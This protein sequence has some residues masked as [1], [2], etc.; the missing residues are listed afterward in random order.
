MS[1][2]LPPAGW[3]M[4]KLYRKNDGVILY[5]EAW[6]NQGIV[7]VHHG[8]VGDTCQTREI[9]IRRTLDMQGHELNSYG[10]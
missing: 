9:L 2:K 10:S 1:K 4:I 3:K 6:A 8:V 7:T 5:W